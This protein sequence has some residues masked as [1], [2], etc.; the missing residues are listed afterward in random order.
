MR[1]V[2]DP[3]VINKQEVLLKNL[4]LQKEIMN[5]Q[6]NAAFAS[7]IDRKPYDQL[8]DNNIASV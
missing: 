4:Q 5:S 1:A 2:K 8:L 3:Q 6:N 7:T